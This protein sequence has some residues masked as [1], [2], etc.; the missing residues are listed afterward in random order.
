MVLISF[1]SV[2]CVNNFNFPSTKADNPSTFTYADFSEKSC[3]ICSLQIDN[4]LIKLSEKENYGVTKLIKYRTV[5]T[6]DLWI[7]R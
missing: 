2:I 7:D 6:L 5:A 1:P 4:W 3:F